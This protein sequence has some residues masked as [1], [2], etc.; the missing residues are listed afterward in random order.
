[1]KHL[2]EN[3]DGSDQHTNQMVRLPWMSP[4]LT[5]LK[6]V[7]DTDIKLPALKETT[8]TFVSAFGPPS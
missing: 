8:S 4:Q 2:I 7:S 6:R 5:F 3:R 1:M